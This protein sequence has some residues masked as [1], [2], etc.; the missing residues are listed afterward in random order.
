M[1][2]PLAPSPANLI[3]VARPIPDAA[4][5]TTK[6]F[7]LIPFEV[8]AAHLYGSAPGSSLRHGM[9]SGLRPTEP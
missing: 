7:P 3:A 8:I 5:L 1:D 4:P 6:T 9:I 2:S